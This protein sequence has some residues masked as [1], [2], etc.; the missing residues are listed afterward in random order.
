[1]TAHGTA[2]VAVVS[3]VLGTVLLVDGVA[4]LLE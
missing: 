1:V 4:G 3:L 2:A